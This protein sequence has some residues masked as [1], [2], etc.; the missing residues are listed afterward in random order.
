MSMALHRCKRDK[1]AGEGD[2]GDVMAW[3]FDG[4]SAE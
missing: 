4:G 1:R 3:V 2:D